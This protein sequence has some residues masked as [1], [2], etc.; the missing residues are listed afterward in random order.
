MKIAMR[1]AS[2][3]HGLRLATCAL[4]LLVISACG[5][6]TASSSV[7]GKSGSQFNQIQAAINNAKSLT[8]KAVYTSQ[9]S[10]GSSS[11]TT[12]EQKS[13]KTLFS[14]GDST[15]IFNGTTTI[16]CSTGSGCTTLPGSSN[17]FASA[18]E[19]YSGAY[20][21]T[22]MQAYQNSA[23]L[24]A[25]GV[26]VNYSTAT[27]AGQQSTCTTISGRAVGAAGAGAKWCVTNDGILAYSGGT[28]GSGSSSGAFELTSYTTNVPDSDFQAPA[29]D[30]SSPS[31][32]PSP[33]NDTSGGSSTSVSPT[34]AASPSY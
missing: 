16:E 27:Y 34:D 4:G 22:L 8:F 25:E 10:G 1:L 29:S 30:S 11:T 14:S 28:S 23:V 7:A 20:I 19:L 15:V 12:I 33:T 21:L 13:P 6:V 24:S 2:G 9:S 31:A 5:T 3:Q 32:S 26:S 18:A 17:P